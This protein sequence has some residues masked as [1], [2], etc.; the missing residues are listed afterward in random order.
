M[1]GIE[2]EPFSLG[3]VRRIENPVPPVGIVVAAC[4]DDN[5]ILDFGF[6]IADCGI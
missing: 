3:K 1:G 2:L 5:P 4:A 6:R